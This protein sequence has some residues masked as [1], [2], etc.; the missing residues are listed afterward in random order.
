MIDIGQK[1]LESYNL[2]FEQKS[3]GARPM[4][5]NASRYYFTLNDPT[6]RH[7]GTMEF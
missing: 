1:P 2:N 7:T 3:S 6:K 4:C 5:A